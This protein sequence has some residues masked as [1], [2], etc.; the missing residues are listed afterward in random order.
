ME[1]YRVQLASCSLSSVWLMGLRSYSSIRRFD[2]RP[3]STSVKRCMP[4]SNSWIEAISMAFRRGKM[5]GS[6]IV[7]VCTLSLWGGI[8]GFLLVCLG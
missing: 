4:F 6:W 7:L 1:P 2:S 8:Q 3:S 5:K